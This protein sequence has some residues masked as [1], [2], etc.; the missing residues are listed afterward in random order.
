MIFFSMARGYKK[1]SKI[2]IQRQQIANSGQ[3]E[4]TFLDTLVYSAM[5]LW[6]MQYSVQPFTDNNHVIGPIGSYHLPVIRLI[7][8]KVQV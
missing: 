7:L 3:V 2:L 6:K 4:I 8:Y 1:N 5:E